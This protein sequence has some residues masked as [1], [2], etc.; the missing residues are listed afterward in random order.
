MLSM[1]GMG[2]AAIC[3]IGACSNTSDLRTANPV[4]G[5]TLFVED[6][7]SGSL[8]AWSDGVDPTRHQIVA[9]PG[10]AQSGS[11]L[12]EVTYRAGSDGGWLTHFLPPGYD[13][14][15]VSY[16]VRF[17]EGWKGGTK[18][19]ALY[20]SRS[21]D[22]WSALGKAGK[23]PSGTDFFA[24]ML[25]TELGGDPGPMRFYTYYPAMTP[26]PDGV[27]CWGRYGDGNEHYV[28][29][30]T[31]APGVWHHVEFW[32]KLNDPGQKNA[33]QRFWL[34]GTLRGSWSGFSL[35]RSELLELNAVQLTF[36]R[37]ISGGVTTQKLDV[38]H[39]VVAKRR[40][41]P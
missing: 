35:R 15:F 11:H 41:A 18:L 31:V 4:S 1:W 14:L 17:P 30:L 28:Q 34:D 5:D 37:G 19:I 22:Q 38:D 26:E 24:T 10:R 9:D 29:P 13:S 27:T 33:D 6:F 8:T 16:Y 3:C 39:L 12:L 20:G 36:N 7:E 40:P 21:D 2:L 32:V 23:C 25:I